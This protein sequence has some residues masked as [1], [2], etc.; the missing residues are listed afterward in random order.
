MI[1]PRDQMLQTFIAEARDLVRE[2]ED[3]L[4]QL[5]AG[6]RDAELVARIFRAAHSIKG[7]GGMFG[8]APLVEFTHGLES[9]LERVRAGTLSVDDALADDLIDACDHIADLVELVAVQGGELAGPMLERDAALRANL[10]RHGDPYSAAPVAMAQSAE[11][12]QHDTAPVAAYL[13]AGMPHR[14]C[15][16][17]SVRFG[18]DVHRCGI[19]PLSFIRYLESLGEIVCLTMLVDAMPPGED[20]D[21]EGCYLGFELDL[22][23]PATKAEIAE[24]FEFVQDCSVIH[25]LPPHSRIEQFIEVIQGLP[26]PDVR[27][28][29]I[30][31]QAG[32]ITRQELE[33]GLAEQQARTRISGSTALLGEV[34]VEQKAVVRDVVDAALDTQSRLRRGASTIASPQPTAAAGETG[35]VRVRAD[36]LDELI[37]L[38][39]EL[40]IAGA[41]ASLIAN[42]SGNAP[43]V[44]AQSIASRLMEDIRDRTLR[45]RMVPI[46][47]TFTRF[48]RVLREVS[49]EIGKDIELVIEGAETELDK[50]VVEKLADPLLHLVRN[51]ADHGIES[52]AGRA[53][54]G[55]PAKGCVRLAAA[56][57]AGSIVIEISDDGAGL[58]RELILAKARERGLVLPGQTPTEHEI[59][60]LICEPGFSTAAAVTSLSGRGVGMDVVRRNIIA[61]RGTVEIESEAGRG[62]TV[63]IR[64]PLTLAII[65]GFL[66]SAAA[67]RFVLP[68]DTIIECLEL[69]ADLPPQAGYLDLRGQALPL[70]R[71]REHLGLRGERARREN[72]VVVD[73]AGH[74]AG[75]VVDALLGEFQTVIK[76]LGRLFEGLPGISGSTILGG[77]DVALILDV[78]ELASAARHAESVSL[79]EPQLGASASHACSPLST[80]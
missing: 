73:C 13:H 2:M 36:K 27:L 6:D 60:Q 46:G 23:G 8:L 72:V 25:I 62:T 56:H 43:L 51:A 15:W 68:L 54:A 76:P 16:H 44:E 79:V 80:A 1:A 78:A 29:D 7:S 64:L 38:V 28:G 19:N 4:R 31:V 61:L 24:V 52:P 59:L 67:S 10:A 53:A 45:L 75:V 21:P 70:L 18:F 58:D 41:D 26:E 47:E 11:C 66:V 42:G 22:C 34:L 5:R 71:L 20:M 12:A 9:L 17:V 77:G 40:V 63:R 69:P 35:W 57:E 30:L 37:N 3:G 50:S 32:T 48:H 74:R 49:R 14:D 55:K 65:E 33:L 39:G